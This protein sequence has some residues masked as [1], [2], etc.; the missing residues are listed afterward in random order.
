MVKVLVLL[1]LV[2]GLAFTP[3]WWLDNMIMPQLFDLKAF[4]GNAEA[5]TQQIADGA[6]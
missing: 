4:Y 2:S 6:R 3:V 1:V 5:T